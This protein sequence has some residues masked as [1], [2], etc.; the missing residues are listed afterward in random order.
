M[1]VRV[2]RLLVGKYVLEPVDERTAPL[3]CR[4]ENRRE[5]ED[6]RSFREREDV[7]DDKLWVVAVTVRELECLI[8][9]RQRKISSHW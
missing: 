5:V 8:A 4:R 9:H 7:A 3:R 1:S 2:E 6:L